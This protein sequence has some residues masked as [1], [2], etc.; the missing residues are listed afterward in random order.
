MKFT[1]N[2][3]GLGLTILGGV[4]GGLTGFAPLSMIAIIGVLL[5]VS[6]LDEGFFCD[7]IIANSTDA[8]IRKRYYIEFLPFSIVSYI[9]TFGKATWKIVWKEEYYIATLSSGNSEP[10]KLSR[11]EYIRLR[12]EQ[13]IIYSTELLSKAFMEKTYSVEGIG[14]KRKKARLF[15]STIFAGLM[16]TMATEPGGIYLTLIYEAVFLPMVILWIP[17]YKDAKILQQAYDKAINT[18]SITP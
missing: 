5:F 1:R 13:R 2:I 15:I 6:F 17:E 7:Y 10:I 9:L 12:N 8:L 14:L 3:I 4:L 18:D 11:K 16:L